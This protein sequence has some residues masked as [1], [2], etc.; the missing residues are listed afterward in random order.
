M[1]LKAIESINELTHRKQQNILKPVIDMWRLDFFALK[2]MQPPTVVTIAIA[3][4]NSYAARA[5]WLAVIE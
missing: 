2:F 3:V 4:H 1:R 5:V